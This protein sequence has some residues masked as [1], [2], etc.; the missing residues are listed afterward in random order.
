MTNQPPSS[1]NSTDPEEIAARNQIARHII[2]GFSTQMPALAEFWRHLDTALTD[3]LTLLAQAARLTAD[4]ATARLDRANLLAAIR[5]TLA[6]TA[7]GEGDPL[8]YLRDELDTQ[9]RPSHPQGRHS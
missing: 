6:A 4:L 8:W 5:A 2:A 3:T 7:D 9:Q 1:R